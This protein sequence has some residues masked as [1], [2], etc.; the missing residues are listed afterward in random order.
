M[1]KPFD[2][3]ELFSTMRLLVSDKGDMGG[4]GMITKEEQTRLR[5]AYPDA[6]FAVLTPTSKI[7][8]IIVSPHRLI[9][10]CGRDMYTSGYFG[11]VEVPDERFSVCRVCWRQIE[12]LLPR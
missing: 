5:Q 7:A 10:I 11:F 12:A 3:D 8:H 4:W 1:T 9:P 6:D 2:T